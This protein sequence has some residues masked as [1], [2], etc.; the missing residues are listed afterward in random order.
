MKKIYITGISGTG[1]TTIGKEL[2]KRGYCVF[3]IDLYELGLCSWLDINTGEKA[4]PKGEGKEW[5]DSHAWVCDGEKLKNLINEQKQDVVFAVGITSNQGNYLGLF[6]K[7]LLLQ[8]NEQTFLNRIDSRID[9]NYG[10]EQSEREHLLGFYKSFEENLL[11]KGAISVN[12]DKPI[13]EIVDDIIK[14]I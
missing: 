12:V 4:R 6:D 7:V 14:I 11:N 10:K 13:S 2:Q 8:C 9:N 3:D 1:K 5:L